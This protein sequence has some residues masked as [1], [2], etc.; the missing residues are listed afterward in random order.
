MFF[1]AVGIMNS[2][3]KGLSAGGNDDRSDL[4]QFFFFLLRVGFQSEC[5]GLASL[6]TLETLATYHAVKTFFGFSNG[7]LF[8]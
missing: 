1:I 5:L 4:D 2:G 6:D 3:V 7:L 8:A